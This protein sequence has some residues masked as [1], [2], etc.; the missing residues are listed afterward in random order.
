MTH[1]GPLNELP[2]A[3][4][5]TPEAGKA[6]LQK[7]RAFDAD[8][9]LGTDRTNTQL[10]VRYAK[11]D[12]SIAR[13]HELVATESSCCSFVDWA[14]DHDGAD[15]RLVVTGTADQLAALNVGE[16]RNR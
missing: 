4:T 11:V 9:A 6:Q 16:T 15:L 12:D 14:I 7:W 1:I 8:Y 13:L 2:I 3:C 5:L 10:V